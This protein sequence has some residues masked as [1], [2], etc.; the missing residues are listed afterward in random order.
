MAGAPRLRAARSVA[1]N[2][3]W[4]SK[5]LCTTEAKT[6][7]AYTADVGRPGARMRPAISMCSA[8]SAPGILLALAL[9]LLLLNDI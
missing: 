9:A 6:A 1:I 3:R 4:I 2:T 8:R 7:A 5:Q